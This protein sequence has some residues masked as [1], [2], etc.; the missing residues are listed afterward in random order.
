VAREQRVEIL[1]EMVANVIE[2]V[3][4]IGDAVAI[5]DTVVLLESMKMEIP[6]ISEHDGTVTALK[7]A[8][9][10]VVHVIA[11]TFSAAHSSS[12]RIPGSDPVIAK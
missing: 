9:G 7:V 8:A 12:A 6:V 1:A 5:G 11:F 3:V 4:D 10:D 2:L